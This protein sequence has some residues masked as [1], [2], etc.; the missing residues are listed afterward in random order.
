[1]DSKLTCGGWGEINRD[2]FK[3]ALDPTTRQIGLNFE[4]VNDSSEAVD[5]VAQGTFAFYENSYFLK[6]ALVKRQLRFQT[7]RSNQTAN[8]SQESKDIVREDRTLHIMSDCVIKM[9]ISIGDVSK[10]PRKAPK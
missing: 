8:N 5:R 1:M 10:P 7:S 3:F 4:L 9:P 2:F 6:E